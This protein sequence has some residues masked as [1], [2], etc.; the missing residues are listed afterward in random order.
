MA[1]YE[2]SKDVAG[3]KSF[4]HHGVKYETRKITQK[5]LKIL[6]KS[7]FNHVTEIKKIVKNE[8][9]EENNGND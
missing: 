7:G 8:T 3:S 6:Y 4:R 9:L 5:D 2:L 1:K